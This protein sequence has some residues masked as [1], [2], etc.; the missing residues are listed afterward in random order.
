MNA[1]EAKQLK[2]GDRV[3][4]TTGLEATIQ[5]IDHDGVVKGP[6][7]TYP[8]Y[9]VRNPWVDFAKEPMSKHFPVSHEGLESAIT[10]CR[11]HKLSGVV[12][13]KDK[14]SVE[15]VWENPGFNK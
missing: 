5:S 7:V 4:H 12:Y 2:V 3:I 6:T 11:D 13:L 1:Q 10:Y 14:H 9:A 15:D 8:T